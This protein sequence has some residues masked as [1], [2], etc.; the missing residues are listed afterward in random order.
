MF[1]CFASEMILK[2]EKKNSEDQYQEAVFSSRNFKILG[3]MSKSLF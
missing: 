1:I 3:H 2:N